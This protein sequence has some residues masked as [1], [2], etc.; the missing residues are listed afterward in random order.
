L[1]ADLCRLCA[2]VLYERFDTAR[3]ADAAESE[4]PL[5]STRYN[6]FVLDMKSGGLRRLFDEKPVLLRLIASMTRQWLVTSRDFVVRIDADV[7]AIRHDILHTE[8]DSPVVRVVAGLSDQHRSGQQVL[9]VEFEDGQKVMYKPKD[10]RVD[11]AWHGMVERL[12]TESPIALRPLRALAR[13]G[14]G[15]TEFIDHTGCVDAQGLRRYFRRAGAW[16]ALFYCFAASDIHHENLIAAGDHPVP[17]DLET[18]LQAGIEAGGNH[19]TDATALDAARQILAN[20]V[21]AIGLLPAYRRTPDDNVHAVGGLAAAWTART[22]LAWI[23]IN[24]DTMRPVVASETGTPPS[25]LPQYGGRYARPDHY[26]E[27]LIA[28]FEQYARFLLSYTRGVGEGGLFDGF[29]GLPVRKVIRPTQFYSM[30]LNRLRDD[31]TMAD[32][33]T[34]SAQADFLARL[35]DWDVEGDPMWRLQRGERSALVELNVPMFMMFTDGTTIRDVTGAAVE[36]RAAPGLQRARDRVRNLDEREIAWQTELIRQ[37]SNGTPHAGNIMPTAP[38]PVPSVPRI[39]PTRDIFLAQADTVAEEIQSRAIRR[40]SSA[41]WIGYSWFP[42][43]DELQLAALGPD[44]Y[45]GACGVAL[46]LAAYAMVTRQPRWAEHARAAV[47]HLRADLTSCNAAHLARLLGVGGAA[48]LGSISYALSTMS[49][50]LADDDLLVDAHRAAT[51][52]SDDLIAADR[53]LDV[54]GGSAGAILCL[55]R[56]YEDTRERDA[57]DRA[58]KCGL[59]LL[60]QPRIGPPGRRSWQRLSPVAKPLIGMSHGAAGF[61]YALC[62]LAAATG[63]EEFAE[64]GRECIEFER[65]GYDAERAER[66]DLGARE[67][68]WR[69]QWCHGAVGIGLARLGMTKRGAIGSDAVASDIRTALAGADR[70]WP[71]HVDTLCCGSLGNIELVREAGGVLNRSD[72][73]ELSTRR[74]SA[75]LQTSTST[76]D[77]RWKGGARRFNIG[78]F[79]GLAGVGYTC[80][81]EIDSSVPSVLIWE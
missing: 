3:P 16:L 26:R 46:F 36:T 81:R 37:T 69:S 75:V 33:V 52:I 64:A 44:L 19:R 25:N 7:S 34:W 67:P 48:G 80:L 54:I 20:S 59:H 74:L 40:A 70:G 53:Q 78:L 61:A 12:N 35:A 15:W 39:P 22:K 41:A 65:S 63:R 11:V 28:G 18:V 23:D 14:Y 24:S 38:A 71:G 4:A 30:L 50:M 68:H 5:Q 58:V 62:A 45:N 1:L 51:L 60:A 79:C 21:L 27:D 72:L 56:L 9:R 49:R 77:F 42:Q 31:R 66:A 55:L 6:Q 73:C 32:G 57:L 2:P 10:L 76:G 43:G 13:A 8:A 29:T 47:S 17:I